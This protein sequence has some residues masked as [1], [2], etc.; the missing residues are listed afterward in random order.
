VGAEVYVS[1]GLTGNEAIIVG[2]L[3]PTLKAGDRVA[4]KEA[5]K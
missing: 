3:L 4:T 2:E 5:P 1:A